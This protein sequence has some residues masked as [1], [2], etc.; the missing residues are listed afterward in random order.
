MQPQKRHER[1][2]TPEA[3]GW[4]FVFRDSWEWLPRAPAPSHGWTVKHLQGNLHTPALSG[5]EG[6]QHS[7]RPSP[8]RRKITV[9]SQKK[10]TL[11][12]IF[13][14]P[15]ERTYPYQV[16]HFQNQHKEASLVRLP[17][18]PNTNLPK[19]IHFQNLWVT[20]QLVRRRLTRELWSLTKWS[21]DPQET[22]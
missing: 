12:P 9:G 21:G 14:S 5:T 16:S 1:L 18:Q 2:I 4:M 8:L 17:S 7:K 3:M 6:A 10:L 11:S 19:M 13:N 20:Y 22:G 15:Q